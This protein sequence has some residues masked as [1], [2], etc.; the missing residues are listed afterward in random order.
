MEIR[1]IVLGFAEERID[2]QKMAQWLGHVYKNGMSFE[3]TLEM[4]RAMIDSGETVDL[5][6]ISGPTADKHSTGGVGDKTTLV[7]APL[8]AACG[9]KV[10][11][12]SGRSLG[13]TGGTLDKLESI[14]GFRTNLSNA[15]FK[16]QVEQ[17]GAAIIS[18]SDMLVPADKKIY[19]LRDA[20][21]MVASIP[22]I[23]ASVMSKKI[24]AGAENIVLDVKCGEGAFMK[25][26]ADAAALADLCV[27]LGE[28]AGRKI[29]AMVTMMD[30]PLGHAVG[31]ALEVREALD[32][33]AGRGPS[34]VYM[35]AR[36]ITARMMVMGGLAGSL[37]QA[38]PVI[39]AAIDNGTALAKMSEIIKAQGGDANIIHDYGLLPLPTHTSPVYAAQDGEVGEMLTEQIGWLSKE[40]GGFVFK[41]KTGDLVSVGETLALVY[42]D[43]DQTAERVS[44]LLSE[45]I[46]IQ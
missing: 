31:N 42:A 26:R 19:E 5:S 15:E 6:G 40:C 11:K 41:K 23:A 10:A 18:Q 29:A 14:P 12:M 16:A 39:A 34:D 21:N 22:L 32:V 25:T 27:K 20:T 37:E 33:L 38:E 13:H 35:L 8:A 2:N 1:N 24:A 3:E 45:L 44:E 43:N 7:V 30:A 36:D 9:L 46:F 28:S 4:T 17:V